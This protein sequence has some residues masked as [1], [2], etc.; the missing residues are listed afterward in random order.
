MEVISKTELASGDVVPI[1]T[2]AHKL[3]PNKN[4]I[5]MNMPYT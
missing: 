3:C 5:M 2:C 1:L 4:K